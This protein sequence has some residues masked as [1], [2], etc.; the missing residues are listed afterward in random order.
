MRVTLIGGTAADL[1]GEAHDL[2]GIVLTEHEVQA[3]PAASSG[4]KQV[5][6]PDIK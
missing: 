1:R 5:R 4:E 3:V 6:L 2:T